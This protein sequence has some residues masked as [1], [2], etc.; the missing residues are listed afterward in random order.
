LQIKAIIGDFDIKIKVGDIVEVSAD[1][2]FPCDLLLLHSFTDN[3]ECFIT[4][5]N[6]D[7]ESNLKV[8][9]SKCSIS[10]NHKNESFLNR[11]RKNLCLKIFP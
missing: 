7:G 9:S 8:K 1:E 11:N 5:A 10:V 4:T 3:N 6:L 2:Q